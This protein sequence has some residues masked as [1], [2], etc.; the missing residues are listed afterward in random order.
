MNVFLSV[1]SKGSARTGCYTQHGAARRDGTKNSIPSV[2]WNNTHGSTEVGGY[3]QDIHKLLERFPAG[4]AEGQNRRRDKN[5]LDGSLGAVE[6][7][8]DQKSVLQ[9]R[10]APR[11]GLWFPVFRISCPNVV[12]SVRANTLWHRSEGT[13]TLGTN[14]QAFISLCTA[15]TT[16]ALV[17]LARAR[18]LGG[19]G[20]RPDHPGALQP[21]PP[22]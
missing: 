1:G 22:S 11:F 6:N 15:P 20:H 5:H 19:F 14:R 21:M 9:I 2:S 13:L 3:T 12:R 17:C 16:F 10:S 8:V 7:G 18:C 4:L